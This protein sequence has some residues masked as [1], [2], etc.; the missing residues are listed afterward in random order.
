[1]RNFSLINGPKPTVKDVPLTRSEMYKARNREHLKR[2]QAELD[3]FN[4]GISIQGK[5]HG[6]GKRCD[7][8]CSKGHAFSRR[9]DTLMRSVRAGSPSCPVCDGRHDGRGFEIVAKTRAANHQGELDSFGTGIK[10]VG[11][12]EVG[13]L[14]RYRDANGREFEMPLEK[15]VKSKGIV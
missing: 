12:D 13:I 1:M 10:I 9:P 3:A 6:R 7:F 2:F 15:M 4:A 11:I 5:Y 14:G 8:I